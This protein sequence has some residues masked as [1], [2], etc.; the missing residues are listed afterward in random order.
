MSGA[1]T[2]VDDPAALRALYLE[3]AAILRG[4]GYEP[5]VPHT[6]ATDPVGHPDASAVDVYT[7]DAR[8][9][10]DSDLLVAYLGVPSLGVGGE[11]VLAGSLAVP[12]IA[13]YPRDAVVSRFALGLVR[14][15]G[16]AEVLSGEPGWEDHLRDAVRASRDRLR[17][18]T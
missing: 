5:H 14:S 8:A 16:G 15:H 18:T 2:N 12:I 4:E 10:A 9:V 13:L 17:S 6:S 11:L 7:T 3:I 1:L